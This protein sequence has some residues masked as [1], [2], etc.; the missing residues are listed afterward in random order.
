MNGKVYMAPKGVPLSSVDEW[1]PIGIV[2]EDG[3]SLP[4]EGTSGREWDAST[5]QSLK[6]EITV[7]LTFNEPIPNRIVQLIRGNITP[8]ALPPY[9]GMIPAIHRMMH[10]EDCP[11]C[12]GSGH[13]TEFEEWRDRPGGLPRYHAIYTRPCPDCRGTHYLDDW[14]EA[15][16]L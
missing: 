15:N 14:K 10:P 8:P 12:G 9:R 2:S 11:T 16:T 6:G 5:I 4:V 13:L 7:E 3:Y 1:T